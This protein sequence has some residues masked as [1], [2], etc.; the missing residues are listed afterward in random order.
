MQVDLTYFVDEFVVIGINAL[1][2]L[3]DLIHL[4]HRNFGSLVEPKFLVLLNKSS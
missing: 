1:L 4:Q 3:D 2:L